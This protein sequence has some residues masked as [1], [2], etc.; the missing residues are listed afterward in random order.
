MRDGV[1]PVEEDGRG[2]R[3]QIDEDRD[4]ECPGKVSGSL[5]YVLAGIGGCEG[6]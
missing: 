5:R 6:V 1:E 4:P 2:I 3:E